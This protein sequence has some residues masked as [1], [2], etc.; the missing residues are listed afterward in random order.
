MS[1]AES[2]GGGG[3]GEAVATGRHPDMTVW[4]YWWRLV[5][6]TISAFCLSLWRNLW[7]SGRSLVQGGDDSGGERPEG[8]EGG[9]E[10]EG[11]G[12]GWGNRRTRRIR[13]RIKVD[14][15]EEG[16]EEEERGEL[17]NIGGLEGA[18]GSDK[19]GIGRSGERNCGREDTSEE[20]EQFADSDDDSRRSSPTSDGHSDSKFIDDDDLSGLSADGEDSVALQD[21]PH[22][23]DTVRGSSYKGDS[24]AGAVGIDI[25]AGEM[26]VEG[27]DSEGQS[28]YRRDAVIDVAEDVAGDRARGQVSVSDQQLI[29]RSHSLEEDSNE[30]QKAPSLPFSVSWPSLNKQI[31]GSSLPTLV[32]AHQFK[33]RVFAA[34]KKTWSKSRFW[35]YEAK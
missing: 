27:E 17:R 10:V 24:E 21:D 3:G 23:T 28:H 6:N 1:G 19:K 29:G 7:W 30:G 32:A 15:R 13:R 26:M 22:N 18:G 8:I 34:T 4:R 16:E 2:C 31:S 25:D 33:R 20:V 11:G 12:G 14:E 35:D 9:Q 5:L